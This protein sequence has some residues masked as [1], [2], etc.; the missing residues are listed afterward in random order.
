MHAFNKD[1][2]Q[3]RS[4]EVMLR[5]FR[6]SCPA[7]PIEALPE[8]PFLRLCAASRPTLR[9][10][11]PYS[12]IWMLFSWFTGT[13]QAGRTTVARTQGHYLLYYF[14]IID[15]DDCAGNYNAPRRADRLSPLSIHARLASEHTA[16]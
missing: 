14:I 7:R 2:D 15:G 5:G 10:R 3:P 16:G 13:M 4:A 9:A 8:N 1:R 12:D 11:R 6:L